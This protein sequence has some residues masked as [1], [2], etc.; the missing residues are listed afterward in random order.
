MAIYTM[1]HA[2]GRH[3]I[4][5][6]VRIEAQRFFSA[7][8]DKGADRFIHFFLPAAAVTTAAKGAF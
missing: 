1:A 5:G 6:P 7:G 8:V 4:S 3:R 2:H